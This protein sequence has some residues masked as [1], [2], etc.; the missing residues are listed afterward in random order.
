MSAK[1]D[2]LK[3]PHDIPVALV[4]ENNDIQK[5]IVKMGFFE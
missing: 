1:R 4:F 2:G 3:I 5:P